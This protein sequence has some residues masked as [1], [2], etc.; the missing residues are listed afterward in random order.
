MNKTNFFEKITAE[1][2]FILVNYSTS[3]S[4]C[5]EICKNAHTEI[6]YHQKYV[7][8]ILAKIVLKKIKITMV[9]LAKIRQIVKIFKENLIL[10]MYNG[11]NTED[12]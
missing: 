10:L 5:Q 4:L 12:R 11:I 7:F 6:V 3:N 2:I 9:F 8:M 1:L